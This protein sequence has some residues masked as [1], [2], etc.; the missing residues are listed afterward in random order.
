MTMEHIGIGKAEREIAVTASGGAKDDHG[1][2][3]V[4]GFDTID[5]IFAVVANKHIILIVFPVAGGLPESFFVDEWGTDLTVATSF[6]LFAPEINKFIHDDH[7]LREPVGHARGSVVKE[8]EA[9]LGTE[10]LVVAFFGFS[11]E[12]EVSIEGGF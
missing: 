2:G 10:F 6:M 5:F 12:R 7:A 11:K 9:K 8:K 4:H 1:I 3:A